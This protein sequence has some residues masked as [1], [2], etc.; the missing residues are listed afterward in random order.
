VL[1]RVSLDATLLPP[2]HERLGTLYGARGERAKALAHDRTFVALWNNAD[3]ELQPR[4][5]AARKR[6]TVNGER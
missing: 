5:A 3:P 6:T 2:V 1:D 4:V